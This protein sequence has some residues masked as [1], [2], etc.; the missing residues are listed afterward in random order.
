MTGSGS[1]C[2][3]APRPARHHP[4]PAKALYSFGGA[5]LRGRVRPPNPNRRVGGVV[6][7]RHVQLGRRSGLTARVEQLAHVPG[8]VV[9]QLR[10]ALAELLEQ[11][12]NIALVDAEGWGAVVVERPS[13]VRCG[14]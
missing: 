10:V 3:L 7:T 5:A 11:H 14:W 9:R 2:R 6:R 1:S 8:E 4:R 12:V 13:K